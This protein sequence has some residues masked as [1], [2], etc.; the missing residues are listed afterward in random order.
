MK[1]KRFDAGL[2]AMAGIE[3][4]KFQITLGYD[5]GLVDVWKS[6]KNLSSIRNQNIKVSVGY[7][8]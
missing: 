4:S 6:A 2:S 1:M 3:F 5:F 8:F 7:F